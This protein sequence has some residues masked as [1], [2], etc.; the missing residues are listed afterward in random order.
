MLVGFLEAGQRRQHADP[1]LGRLEDGEGRRL[2][3]LQLVDQLV[4]HRD[5]GDAAVGEALEK[6]QPAHVLVVD[7]E[8]D[9]GRQQ[10]AERRDDAQETRLAVGGV[11][12][13]DDQRQVGPLLVD[14]AEDDGALLVGRAGRRLAARL[15]VAVL[16]LDRA[17]GEGRARRGEKGKARRESAK[18]SVRGSKALRS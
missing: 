4:V 15:P 17:L 12:R 1:L 18:G 7:L 11:E 9:P 16:V 5:L 3:G 6:V 2:A 10:H 13:D 14:D 8:A